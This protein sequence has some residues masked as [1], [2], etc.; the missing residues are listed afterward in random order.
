MPRP[1]PDGLPVLLGPFGGGGFAIA[2]SFVEITRM[3][4][5]GNDDTFIAAKGTFRDMDPKKLQHEIKK[6]L[7]EIGWTQ[8]KAARCIYCENN[9]FDDEDEIRRYEEA[10]K[11]HLSRPTTP[12]EYL[13]NIYDTL[14][15]QRPAQR[16]RKI[17]PTYVP[18]PTLPPAIRSE[19]LRI[20]R[21]FDCEMEDDPPSE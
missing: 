14:C 10:F 9:E 12:P 4:T 15:R 20:S 3:C 17:K 19:M 16:L 6:L 7:R 18:G 8:A 11:K 13:K 21:E 1:G 5:C 2:R